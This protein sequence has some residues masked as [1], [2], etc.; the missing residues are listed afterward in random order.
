MN[1]CCGRRI[2]CPSSHL[3][4]TQI[5]RSNIYKMRCGTIVWLF[6]YLFAVICCFQWLRSAVDQNLLPSPHQPNSCLLKK[7]ELGHCCYL[8]R[9]N[10]ST[11]KLVSVDMCVFLCGKFFIQREVLWSV[12]VHVYLFFHAVLS[13]YTNWTYKKLQISAPSHTEVRCVIV[14]YLGT[15]FYIIF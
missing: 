8:A 14:R 2:R 10:K 4:L 15:T 6:V 3:E 9:W 12:G 1:M 7:P 5:H 13:W 11:L